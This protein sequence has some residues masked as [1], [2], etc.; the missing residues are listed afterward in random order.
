MFQARAANAFVMEAGH[1]SPGSVSLEATRD[2]DAMLKA[3]TTAVERI[4]VRISAGGQVNRQQGAQT[5]NT[6][7]TTNIN[8]GG[9]NTPVNVS[10]G[11]NAK[12][13]TSV[14]RQLESASQTTDRQG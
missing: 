6:S 10:S 13:L 2:T 11:A 7:I 3:A 4:A 14:L 12:A 8:F 9:R 5:E 1:A